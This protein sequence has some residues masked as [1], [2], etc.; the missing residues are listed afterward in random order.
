MS[1]KR[2]TTTKTIDFQSVVG[3]IAIMATKQSPSK[4]IK[5]HLESHVLKN[6]MEETQ[7]YKIKP[8]DLNSHEREMIRRE[9]LAKYKLLN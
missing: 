2:R 6:I 3:K 7:P 4:S 8:D 1:G 9:G 5:N